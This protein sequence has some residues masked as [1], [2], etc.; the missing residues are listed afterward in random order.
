MNVTEIKKRIASLKRSGE[1]RIAEIQA[2]GLACL[3]QVELH[4]NTTP[5]NDLIGALSRPETKAFTEWALAFGKV[6]KASKAAAEKG[7]YLA[8]DKTKT[9]DIQAASEQTWDTFAPEKQAAVQRAFD[10][11]AAVM[12]VLRRAAEAG[13]P[14]SVLDAIAKAAGIEHAPKAVMANVDAA[15]SKF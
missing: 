12:K 1:K 8:Y 3:E 15:P 4:N 9:T 11:Q 5:I 10:L 13:Q 6:K 14:Q 7:Q 2:V